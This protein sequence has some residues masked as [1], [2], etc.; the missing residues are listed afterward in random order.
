VSLEQ[1]APHR[2]GY[3]GGALGDVELLVDVVQ[4]SLDGRRAEV[5]RAPDP[6]RRDAVRDQL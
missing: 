4:V 3:R 2:L 6:R 1:P 5:K